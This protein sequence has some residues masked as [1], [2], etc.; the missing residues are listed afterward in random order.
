MA[1]GFLWTPVQHKWF[2]FLG[3]TFPLSGGKGSANSNTLKRVAMDQFLMAPCGMREL[4]YDTA[5]E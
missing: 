3:H 2:S 5:R 1:Y 4:Y